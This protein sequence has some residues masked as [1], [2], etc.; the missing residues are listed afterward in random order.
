[1]SQKYRHHGYRDSEHGDSRERS[2]SAPRQQL[3]KEEQIQRRSLRHAIDREA[4]AVIRCHKCG[5]NVPNLD[6]ILTDTLCPSC[7]APL[8]CCRTCSHFDSAARWQCRADITKAIGDKNKAN[9]CSLHAARRVLDVTG[10]RTR[11]AGAGSAKSQFD[12]LFKR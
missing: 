9:D 7:A 11:N 12:N 2:K 4:N 5:R 8:H 1:M 3:T 10:R 6:V